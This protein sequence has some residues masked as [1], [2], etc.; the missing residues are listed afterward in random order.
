VGGGIA[1]LCTAELFS[2]NNFKVALIEKEES[3]CSQASGAHHGWFHFGSLYSIFPNNQFLRTLVGGVDDLIQFYSDFPCMNIR[4]DSKGKLFFPQSHGAW[5]R[6]DPLKFI[7]AS[8]NN[9]D[10]SLNFFGNFSE[11]IRKIFFILTWDLAVKQFISRHQRF[12]KFNWLAGPAST[13]IPKAG[14]KDYSRDLIFKPSLNNCHID[15]NTHFGVMGFD[16]PMR[17]EFIIND[18]LSSFLK[19]GGNYINNCEY[20]GY[21]KSDD[22]NTIITNK[23]EIKSKY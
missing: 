7:V 8:R 5:F 13:V 14:W 19:S 9:E 22:I 18:L 2:R 17:P 10:F 3:I 12:Y 21:V 11:Y 23:S 16:R 6:D 15:P 4:I 1:G 20:L